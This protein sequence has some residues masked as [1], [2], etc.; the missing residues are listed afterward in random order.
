MIHLDKN[1]A[2]YDEKSDHISSQNIIL[3]KCLK[4]NQKDKNSLIYDDEEDRL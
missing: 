3:K 2:E 1:I 4:R